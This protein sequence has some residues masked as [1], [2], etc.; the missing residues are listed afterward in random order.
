MQIIIALSFLAI[1]SIFINIWV[2]LYTVKP[3]LFLADFR[4]CYYAAVDAVL[5][6]GKDALIPFMMNRKFVNLPI[7]VYLFAPFPYLGPVGAEI[8]F[9]TL[10]MLAIVASFLILSKGCDARTRTILALAFVCNGPLWYSLLDMGNT[11]HFILLLLIV[12]LGLLQ[13]KKMYST[14]LLIGFCAT[15]KPMISIFLVYFL[16][17]RNWRAA[18]SCA[19]VAAVTVVSSLAVFGWHMTYGWYEWCIVQYSRQTIGAFNNQSINAFLLRMATGSKY[20]YDWYLHD[21]PF[22]TAIVSKIMSIS[23]LALVVFSSFRWRARNAGYA[24]GRS[25]MS[26]AFDFSLLIAFCILTS[27]VSW[28]HYYLLLLLPWSLYITGRLPLP[29][30]PLTDRMVVCG[31][32]LCSLPA[33]YPTVLAG[34][35]GFICTRTLASAWLIG[36]FVFLLALFRSS[37]LVPSKW[38]VPNGIGTRKTEDALGATARM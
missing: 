26:D 34:R 3:I 23:L 12:S 21:Q 35:V 2:P 14:G 10:G 22:P 7:D 24:D 11:T 19:A 17:R 32:V 25:D 33:A 38:R 30:G 18:A 29:G 16:W 9:C 37:L 28:T 1:L 27:P 20:I 15:I 5:H 6:R 8:A 36:A 13:R 4:D 31:M